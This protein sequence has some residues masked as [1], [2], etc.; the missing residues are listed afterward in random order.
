MRIVVTI[1]AFDDKVKLLNV[2]ENRKTAS[3]KYGVN[4]V[5]WSFSAVCRKRN[6]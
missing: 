3:G 1:L 5:T 4:M 6:S 2:T